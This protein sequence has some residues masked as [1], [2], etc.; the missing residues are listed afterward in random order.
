[1]N[2]SDQINELITSLSVAT[3]GIEPPKKVHSAEIATKTGGKYSY[4]YSGLA[5][6]V[7]TTRKPLGENGLV[8]MQLP[9]DDDKGDCV[10][11]TVLAHKSGQW[12]SG[13]LR[14]TPIEKNPQGFGSCLTY[15]R[16]Y[17]ALMVLGLAPEDDDAQA[18]MGSG[19]PEP[20]G[21]QTGKSSAPP[22]M[23]PPV[24]KDTPHFCQVHKCR[25]YENSP[26]RWS[27][28]IAGSNPPQ[29]CNEDSGEKIFG[30]DDVSNIQVCSE[31][32]TPDNLS[33]YNGKMLCVDCFAKAE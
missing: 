13:T 22:P 6:A 32:G 28:K 5:E 24:T 3:A 8:L 26:G 11:E 19:T 15:C 23:H 7:E 14:M 33:E 18:S 16:R 20:A 29:Y 27:H 25:F 4:T 9:H 2:S 17:S 31:C 1:M 30:P 21:A 10:V 12:I